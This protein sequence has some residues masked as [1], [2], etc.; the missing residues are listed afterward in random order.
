MKTYTQPM[1]TES[2]KNLTILILI[3]LTF[4][5]TAQDDTKLSLSLGGG[6]TNVV[7]FG[8][9]DGIYGAIA[10]QLKGEMTIN[11]KIIGSIWC[12]PFMLS[13]VKGEDASNFNSII[14]SHGG[15]GYKVKLPTDKL[16]VPVML[17]GGWV[18]YV[19][20][21]NERS[22]PK[23]VGGAQIGLIIE[24]EYKVQDRIWIYGSLRHFRPIKVQYG[25]HVSLTD[26]SLGVKFQIFRKASI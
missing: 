22:D 10:Y 24:P 12:N 26:I 17:G 15:L 9:D 23:R 13:T 11:D 20:Q 18:R 8:Y 19:T 14:A 16:Q 1:K 7:N 2:L 25:Q 3:F 6:V 4:K 21:R 5:A